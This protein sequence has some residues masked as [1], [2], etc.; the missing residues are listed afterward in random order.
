MPY[1]EITITVDSEAIAGDRVD[2]AVRVENVD[3]VNHLIRTSVA[4]PFA[5]DG[6]I[7]EADL[8][9]A[10]KSRTYTSYFMMPSADAKVMVATWYP[11]GAEWHLDNYEEKVV[12][13]AAPPEVYEG[14]ISRKELEYDEARAYIPAYDILQDKRGLVHI[15]GRNDMSTN[16]KMGISWI[17]SDPDGIVVEEYSTWETFWTGPGNEQHF[18]GGRFNLDKAG[19]YILNVGLYMNREAPEMVDSYY[20]TLCTIALAVPEPEFRGFGVIEYVTK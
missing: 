4:A 15:W 1:T 13:L 3:S 17:I 2:I 18:I 20:G 12:S 11:V 8:I 10:G 16:Q 9:E 5:G 14:T 6:I 7:D 19:T